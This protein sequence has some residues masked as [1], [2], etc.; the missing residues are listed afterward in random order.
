M[1]EEEQAEAW[2]LPTSVLCHSGLAGP[3]IGMPGTRGSP[4]TR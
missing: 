2:L 3:W 1:N 4:F